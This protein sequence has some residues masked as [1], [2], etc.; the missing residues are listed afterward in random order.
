MSAQVDRALPIELI[1]LSLF[2]FGR[3]IAFM[4]IESTFRNSFAVDPPNRWL[5]IDSSCR[6]R[7]HRRSCPAK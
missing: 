3:A 2:R 5:R 6:C 4:G 7:M 1:E